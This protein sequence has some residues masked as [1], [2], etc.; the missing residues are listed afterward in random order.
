MTAIRLADPSRLLLR[1]PLAALAAVVTAMAL[2]GA[3]ISAG[4]FVRGVPPAET[5][6]PT[7][8][9]PFEMGETAQTRFGVVAVEAVDRLKGLTARELA[10]MNH[11]ISGYVPPDKVQVQVSVTM[12]NL[13]PET[14][15]WSPEQFRLVTASSLRAATVANGRGAISSSARPGTL[16]P[17]AGLDTRIAYLVPR[18]RKGLYLQ[19][20]EKPGDAPLVFDLGKSTGR[21]ASAKELS[22]GVFDHGRHGR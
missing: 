3:I 7:K 11:G 20:R 22:T 14:T 21:P 17:D 18:N 12:R 10:G 19:Y 8:T 9:G 1:A 15:R 2:A 13:L 16:Q 4:I 5:P 6:A